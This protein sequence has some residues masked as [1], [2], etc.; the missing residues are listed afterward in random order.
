M[1]KVLATFVFVFILGVLLPTPA[2]AYLLPLIGT[3]SVILSMLVGVFAAICAALFLVFYNV[4][5]MWWRFKNKADTK[6]YVSDN[7]LDH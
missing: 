4:R 2:E 3:G 5:R 1:N 7:P 6:D